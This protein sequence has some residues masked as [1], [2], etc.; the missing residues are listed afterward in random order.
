MKKRSLVL[1]SLLG[2]ALGMIT[3]FPLSW[4]AP[5]VMPEN[6]GPNI[7]YSG[8]LWSGRITGLDYVGAAEFKLAPKALLKGGLPLSFQTSSSAMHISGEASRTKI[9]GLRFSG[10]LAGLP[11]NDGR[12]KE[13]V[14]EVNI[15]IEQI[16]LVEDCT[17][18][19]GQANTDFLSRNQA[20]W[21]WRGPALSG[22]ITCE[23]GDLIANLSGSEDAQSI[24]ADLR[25]MPD[26]T[27]RAD[28][29]VRTPQPEAG[30]VL[31]L[32]G[33]EKKNGEFRL[34]EQG[35]WR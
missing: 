13:L 21:Q 10:Q 20:R 6:L 18:A 24:K 31:P 25:I 16:I 32:Y 17:S 26:G 11:T 12:L 15:N 28:I 35:K 33:F 27:Y 34:T 2:A 8:T 22:P 29:S 30:V 5:H 3:Q 1:V 4:V 9:E 7:R 14:G 23:S 19:K